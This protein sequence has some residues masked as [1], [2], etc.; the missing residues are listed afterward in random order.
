MARSAPANVLVMRRFGLSGAFL[1]L[2]T[3]LSLCAPLIAPY[4]PL[5]EVGAALAAPSAQHRLGTDWIGRDVFS[6]LLHGGGRT[7]SIGLI[8][9]GTTVLIGG[10]VGLCAGFFGGALDW[11]I[12]SLSDALLALP[13]L[14]IALSILTLAGNGSTQIALAAALSGLPVYL[15]VVRA[16]ARSLR[17]QPYVEAA[18]A[19]GAS[20]LGV[21]WRHVLPNALP[22]CLSAGVIAVAW[23]ILNAATLHFLGFGGDPSLPEWGAMLAEGRTVLRAAPWIALSAGVALTLTLFALN[24][25]ARRLA[26]Q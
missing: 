2:L 17:V 13:S 18:R 3:L 24:D 12:I 25:A 4:D 21:L 14:L 10:I 5:A 16:T 19:L 22:M 23:A 26:A 11:L 7:L 9:L 6:R 1:A 15:R 8:A 20:E